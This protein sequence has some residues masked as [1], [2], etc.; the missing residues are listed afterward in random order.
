MDKLEYRNASILDLPSVLEIRFSV[1]EN[2]LDNP[3]R[4]TTQILEDYLEM[5]FSQRDLDLRGWVCERNGRVVGF[6]YAEKGNA[7]I[8]GLFVAPEHAGKGIGKGLLNLAVSWLFGLG[9]QQ[10]RLSTG[11]NTRAAQFY[12]ALGWRKTRMKNSHEAWFCLT[13]P[14]GELV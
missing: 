3:N 14:V 2:R 5:L 9:L 10:I 13:R 1:N 4:V 7:S 6:C 11:I 12:Q 8:W